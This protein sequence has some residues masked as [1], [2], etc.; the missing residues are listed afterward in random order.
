MEQEIRFCTAADGTR[1]AYSLVG[2][3]PPLVKAPNWLTHIEFE[4]KSPVWR[5]W[6]VEL[7]KN[8]QL[9]RFDQ[10]GSGLSDR[11]VPEQSFETW[12]SDLGS[13]V[14][15][16]G[17]GPFPLLG[18]SQGGAIA[19]AYTAGH[20]GRVSRLVM[21]GAYARGRSKRGDSTE[22][23]EAMLTLTRAGWGRDDPAYRQMFT[24]R[25]MPGATIEQMG[26]FNDLQRI[27]TSG[28]NAAAVL[29]E[30]S[31]IDVLPI[32]NRI[33]TP[34]LVLHARGDVQVP[35]E[36]GRQL[37]SLIPGARFVALE[38]SNHLL[39]ESEPAWQ[40]VLREVRAFLDP[41]APQSTSESGVEPADV[42][43]PA[44][45]TVREVEVLSLIAS[46]RS[47]RALADELFI[48]TNTVANHVKNIL[49]KTDS[50]NR[51]EAAAFAV[52]HDLT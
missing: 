10:R 2:N 33:Q 22:E 49:S 45:L 27:S 46:G 43:P 3:G 28:D 32:L 42:A 29:A 19:A 47:N 31:Q 39:L 48:T 12:V 34:T 41:D 44:G 9:I 18:I 38:G 14:D 25:F 5:H 40:V 26:W 37:A 52:E 20:P 8:H 36:Q 51:T 23:L 24:S 4:W 1:I 11:S 21:Y 16:L 50:A 17:L 6:W 13:V 15:D 7:A 30:I 35:F